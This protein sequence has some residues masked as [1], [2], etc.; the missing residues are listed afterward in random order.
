[1][2]SYMESEISKSEMKAIRNRISAQL[3]R[4]RKKKEFEDLQKFSQKLLDENKRLKKELTTKNREIINFKNYMSN[5]CNNCSLDRNTSRMNIDP[6][7][8]NNGVSLRTNN[9]IVKYGLVTSFLVIICIISSCFLTNNYQNSTIKGTLID[10]KIE[11]RYLISN[12]AESWKDYDILQEEGDKESAIPITEDH[13]T[14][15]E[16]NETT[17]TESE[18]SQKQEGDEITHN[19]ALVTREDIK[20]KEFIDFAV[21]AN[22]KFQVGDI[23]LSKYLK[24]L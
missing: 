2:N 15:N 20:K 17:W 24:Y 14:D 8:I 6:D 18:D 3:S 13:K 23:N 9:S 19:N 11:P 22:R 16:S 4:D 1:M 10:T 5:L 7:S 21:F 12:S